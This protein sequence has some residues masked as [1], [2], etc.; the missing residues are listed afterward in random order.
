MKVMAIVNPSSGVGRGARCGKEILKSGEKLDVVFTTLAKTATDFARQAVREN[1]QR[2]IGVG[3]DG[4]MCHIAN[5]LAGSNIPLAVVPAG[6]GND[7]S[8]ALGI[9]Q[10]TKTALATALAG[11]ILPIDLGKI[12]DTY[13]VNVVS[14]GLDAQ[15]TQHVPAMKK[16]YR[17][18]PGEGLYLTALFR[19]LCFHLEYPEI[20]MNF[21][22]GRMNQTL[23]QPTTVLVISNGPQYGEMFKIA[24]GA[25]LVD[26]LLDVCWIEKMNRAKILSNLPKILLGTHTKLPEVKMF[27]LISLAVSSPA[28]LACQIDG[29]IFDSAKAYHYI[30]VAPKALNVIVPQEKFVPQIKALTLQPV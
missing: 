19:E 3:G 5:G 20:R 15:L 7:F 2:V 12:D 9:P 23:T 8:K 22:D 25:S 21:W 4:T 27:K 14:F 29:E 17:F 10:D 24:P 1:Y 18:L 6:V 30:R 28:K 11:K 26:G 13:F 16:K